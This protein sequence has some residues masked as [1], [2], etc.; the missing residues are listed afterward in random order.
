MRKNL[1][2]IT[3]AIL[4]ALFAGCSAKPAAENSHNETPIEEQT[5]S[6]KIEL[7]L[8]TSVPE[9]ADECSE[10]HKDKQRLIDTAAPEVEVEHESE[11]A[12]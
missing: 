1:A 6:N 12:G 10:C 5:E 9:V 4:A 3:L 8:P 11:G 2:L 7:V